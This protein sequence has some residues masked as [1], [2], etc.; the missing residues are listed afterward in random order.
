MKISNPIP[1]WERTYD[2]KTYFGYEYYIHAYL[3]PKEYTY[4]SLKYK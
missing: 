1:M 3:K 4:W 2:T